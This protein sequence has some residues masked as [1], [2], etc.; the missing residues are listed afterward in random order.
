VSSTRACCIRDSAVT[1]VRRDAADRVKHRVAIDREVRVPRVF[2]ASAERLTQIPGI[3]DVVVA[4]N[5]SD[6]ASAR[7]S[8]RG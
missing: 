2:K 8:Q 1:P 6:R 4:A 3:T 5:V 7:E